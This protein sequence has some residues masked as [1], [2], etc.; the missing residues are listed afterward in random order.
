MEAY[1][2]VESSRHGVESLRILLQPVGGSQRPTHHPQHDVA[3]HLNY[4]GVRLKF[5][6]LYVVEGQR[7][8]YIT[9]NNNCLRQGKEVNSKVTLI[10]YFLRKICYMS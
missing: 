10:N 8:V 2:L 9:N 6:W 3:V 5:V 1:C 7:T 4:R